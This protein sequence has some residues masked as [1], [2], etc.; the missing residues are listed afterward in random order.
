M[1]VT[2]MA[3]ISIL[4]KR[5][6]PILEISVHASPKAAKKDPYFKAWHYGKKSNSDPSVSIAINTGEP[7]T[8]H[9][10]FSD[11]ELNILKKWTLKH[12]L[13]LLDVY[14]NYVIP[15]KKPP[16]VPGDWQD[17][18]KSS[19]PT[20]VGVHADEDFNLFL[21]FSG[22][23]KVIN[24][25]EYLSGTGSQLEN[26]SYFVK[27]KL[28]YGR[29]TWPNTVDMEVEDLYDLAVDVKITGKMTISCK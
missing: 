12:Q 9:E 19:I 18:V 13:V 27:V 10:S 21:N 15:A 14:D 16:N 7:I 8:Q 25:K 28:K 20:L 26:P 2:S 11:E 4:K 5:S 22:H 6:K 23:M 1:Q 17:K 3:T 24:M 29:P